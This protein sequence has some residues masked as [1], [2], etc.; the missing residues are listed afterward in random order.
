M[1]IYST[2]NSPRISQFWKVVVVM[3]GRG[4]PPARYEPVP[5][6]EKLIGIWVPA[7]T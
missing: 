7:D 6:L 2:T 5:V 1:Y 4:N 3:V